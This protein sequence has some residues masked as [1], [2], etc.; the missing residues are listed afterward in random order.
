MKFETTTIDG[1]MTRFAASRNE[2][3][4]Q[5]LLTSPQPMSVLTYRNWWDQL[6]KSFD[7]VAV[8]RATAPRV[9]EV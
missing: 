7:V 5:L 4:P 2:G 3:K 6:S 8:A 9:Q 1:I